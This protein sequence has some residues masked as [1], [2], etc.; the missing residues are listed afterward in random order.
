M[1]AALLLLLGTGVGAG[2]LATLLTQ[3]VLHHHQEITGVVAA[4][5]LWMAHRV[6]RLY[7]NPGRRVVG[8]PQLPPVVERR[9]DLKRTKTPKG[10]T[11]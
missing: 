7:T 5:L 1:T 4:V 3:A 8:M 10:V 11:A 2:T 9:P 6:H